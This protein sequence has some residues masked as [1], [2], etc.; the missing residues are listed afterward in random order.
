MH[1]AASTEPVN[2]SSDVSRR[3]VLVVAYFFPPD[4]SSG[5]FRTLKFVK[6]LPQLG[7]EPVVLTVDPSRERFSPKDP[8]LLSQVPAGTHVLRTWAFSPGKWVY[9]VRNRYLAGDDAGQPLLRMARSMFEWLILFPDRCRGWFPF[10]VLRGWRAIR[11]H[12]IDVIYT[13]APPNTT[14]LVGLA[15]HKLT[16]R[17]LVSD[18]RD[19]WIGNPYFKSCG[20]LLERTA[21]SLESSVFSHSHRILNVSPHL[22]ELASKRTTSI[23]VERFVTLPNG[24]DP[25]DCESVRVDSSHDKFRVTYTGV[26]YPPRRDPRAF[27]EAIV[28]A[29]GKDPSLAQDLSVAL[30][31]DTNWAA[32]NRDWSEERGLS[33][34]V[35]FLDYQPHSV[36]QTMLAESDLLLL[37][38]SYDPSER[39]NIPAKVFEYIAAGRPILALAHEGGLTDL[40]R[41]SGI[42]RVADPTDP[43]AIADVLLSL[44]ADIR[45]GRPIGQRNDE[46][47]ER[48][49]RRRQAGELAEMFESAMGESCPGCSRPKR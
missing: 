34:T 12:R 13:S 40:V 10:A 42:G 33:K 3:R 25:D 11:K 17:P 8:A 45:A 31:G 48:Y 43:E 41:N 46:L 23:P 18:F 39:G 21:R 44:H 1:T 38:G 47:M 27:L 15:L 26:F 6:Y 2:L 35:Q 16:G 49:N 7:W 37:I 28:L 20:S 22:T 9:A 29:Q 30:V 36:S 4:S 14:S 5:T 32:T 24:F 19:P